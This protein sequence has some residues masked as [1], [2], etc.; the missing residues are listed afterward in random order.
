MNYDG[1]EIDLS[2]PGV[3]HLLS[4]ISRLQSELVALRNDLEEMT[5]IKDEGWRR[6]RA[7]IV[8]LDPDGDIAP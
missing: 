3:K 7:G 5:R 6:V 4:E 8:A 2:D 1:V